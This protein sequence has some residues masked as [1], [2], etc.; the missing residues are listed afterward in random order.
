MFHGSEEPWYFVTAA[1]L[2]FPVVRDVKRA[3]N[4]AFGNKEQEEIFPG[5]E[6]EEMETGNTRIIQVY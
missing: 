3:R 4:K 2:S 6:E 5:P 1:L